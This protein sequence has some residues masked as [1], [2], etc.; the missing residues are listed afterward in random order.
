MLLEVLHIICSPYVSYA[1]PPNVWTFCRMF[2]ADTVYSTRHT[3]V[4]DSLDIN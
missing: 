4:L 2:L 1:S 3:W